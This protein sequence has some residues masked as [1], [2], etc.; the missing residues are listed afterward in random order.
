MTVGTIEQS[1]QDH[2]NRDLGIPNFPTILDVL[3]IS[4][5]E[6]L[7]ERRWAEAH[8][9]SVEMLGNPASLDFSDSNIVHPVG[10]G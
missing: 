1:F 3:G 8:H 5:R 7:D 10:S 9:W 6:L 2:A 4:L